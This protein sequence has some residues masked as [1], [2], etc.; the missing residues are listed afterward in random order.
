[1]P[2]LRVQLTTDVAVLLKLAR[3]DAFGDDT[4]PDPDWRV[5]MH[6]RGRDDDVIFNSV[7]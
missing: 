3:V 1:V 7:V 5:G 6:D 4:H 2:E